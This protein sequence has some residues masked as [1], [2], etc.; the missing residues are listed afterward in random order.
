MQCFS[1]LLC[2]LLIAAT[3]TAQQRFVD[4]LQAA[5]VNTRDDSVRFGLL[6]QAGER[7]AFINP[8]S[9]LHYT[10]EAIALA[11]KTKSLLWKAHTNIP[12][13]FYF[14]VT[15]DMASAL[16]AAFKNVNDY[17]LHQDV[18]LYAGPT[19]FIGILYM[20][21]GNYTEAMQY[22]TKSLQICDTMKWRGSLNA[23]HLAKSKE[24][25][26]ME[27]YMVLA[28]S[29]LHFNKFDSALVYGRKA[30]DLN[31]RLRLNNNYPFYRLALVY[32]KIGQYDRALSL[33]RRAI[34][35]AVSQN[36]VK[37]A[38]DSYNGMAN[39][40]R[41]IGQVDS[42][43]FYAS[44]V[45]TLSGTSDYKMGTLEASL[46]LSA[47]YEKQGKNE[48]A[49]RYYKLAMAAKDSLFNQQKIQQVQAIAFK[50]ELK[51]REL[52]QKIATEQAQYR[53]RF[54]LY[55]VIAAAVIFLSI[56]LLLW[57]NNLH[58]QKA[59]A[60][61]QKQKAKTE[62]ALTKL[63]ATQAQLIQKE[64]MASLG[65]LTAGIAHEIQNPLNFVNNFSAVNKELVEEL[66]TEADNGNLLEVRALAA[67]VLS[68]LDKVSHHGRRADSIVKSMLQHS[69]GS[70]GDQQL[71]NIN[72]LVEEHLRLAYHG[73]RAKDQS[74]N[75]DISTD[76][77]SHV[78]QL[79]VVPQDIGRV[80]L[81]LFNNAFYAV[82]EKKARLNGTFE[83]LVTVNTKR[84]DN[85][86]QIV[87][88]DNGTGMPWNVAEKVFQPFFTTKPTGEGT[89]LGLSLSYDII[90]KGHGGELSVESK[91]SEGS[92]FVIQLPA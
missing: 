23:F 18:Y 65:E 14:F 92:M 90:T 83:P 24:D 30:Y 38:I 16:E 32:A 72:Q 80:L 85:C 82:Q 31:I 34:P 64:K 10:K 51:A 1:F 26:M 13:S 54:R 67:D 62:E 57:R 73:Y 47:L 33:F 15:G 4:S 63:Q 77:D 36:F 3:S 20:N 61:L 39:V 37:D 59:Y 88:K 58:R 43:I 69:R 76:Y 28:M 12:I 78:G 48:D 49:F 27:D 17:P 50:E 75:A 29:Y 5:L 71:T 79:N 8:D 87:V 11:E 53:S 6:V 60:L 74:F 9:S 19:T 86:I 91:E 56:A 21:N 81:N 2:C 22:A 66:K 40:F 89:G 46:S 35:L 42:A 52:R 68:N 55:L 7:Y 25:L 70:S 84:A 41:N 44:K 45:M